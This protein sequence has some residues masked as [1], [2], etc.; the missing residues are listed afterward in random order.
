[1]SLSCIIRP[2]EKNGT[3]YASVSVCPSVNINVLCLALVYVLYLKKTSTAISL[4][5]ESQFHLGMGIYTS[6]AGSR[7]L[8]FTK[9]TVPLV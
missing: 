4:K 9:F 5:L 3:Y 1:M 6:D 8:F 7:L 2:C